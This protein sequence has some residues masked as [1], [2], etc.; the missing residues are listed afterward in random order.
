MSE[1]RDNVPDEEVD[2]EEGAEDDHKSENNG[3]IGG[4]ADVAEN[5]SDAGNYLKS[6]F[7][8][9]IPAVD[10][11]FPNVLFITRF[12]RGTTKEAIEELMN[13]FGVTTFITFKETMAFVD[14]ANVDDAANAK[15][16]LH[17]NPGL[18]SNALIVDFKKDNSA[19]FQKVSH[20][21]SK[22]L[23]QFDYY[24]KYHFILSIRIVL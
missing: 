4:D 3:S 12:A 19:S 18:G 21:T 5:G 7:K 24:L 23:Q 16:A 15:K 9:S 14:F 1:N 10:G 11:V 8:N 2:F 13:S 22:A 6:K 17:G 20:R